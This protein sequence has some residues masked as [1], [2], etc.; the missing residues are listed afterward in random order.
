MIDPIMNLPVNYYD[1]ITIWSA[2]YKEMATLLLTRVQLGVAN[3]TLQ[4]LIGV[5]KPFIH[6]TLTS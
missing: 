4:R 2:F 5:A 1:I 3:Y 6:I